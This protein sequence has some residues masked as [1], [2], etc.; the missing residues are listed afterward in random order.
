MSSWPPADRWWLYF[1]LTALL[2]IQFIVVYGGT[3]WLT[4]LRSDVHRVYFDWE[5]RIPLVPAMAWVYGSIA[6]LMLLPVFKLDDAELR[7]LAGQVSLAI[8]IAGCVFLVYPAQ[9]GYAAATELTPAMNAIRRIDLPYN[10]IPSL[11]V[12]LSALIVLFV[13]RRFRFPGRLLLAAW[14]LAMLAS[15]LLTHQHHVADILGAGALVWICRR[16]VPQA[17]SS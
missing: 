1:R 16:L 8:L 14:M 13:F 17:I 10:L 15:V 3:N 11:H 12:A 6:L 5:L 7:R 2:C 9:T 4:D